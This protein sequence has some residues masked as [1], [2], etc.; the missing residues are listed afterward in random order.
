MPPV[1]GRTR[2][3]SDVDAHCTGS[4]VEISDD[5]RASCCARLRVHRRDADSGHRLNHHRV[6]RTTRMSGRV[7]A[8]QQST[9]NPNL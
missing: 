8:R 4:W 3:V 6:R 9:G 1:V 5:Q 7:M 2:D